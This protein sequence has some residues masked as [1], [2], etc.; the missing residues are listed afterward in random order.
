MAGS[1]TRSSTQPLVLGHEFAGV[2]EQGTLRGR[3]VAVDPAIPCGSC[4]PCVTGAVNLCLRTRF[5]GHGHDR[6]CAARVPRLA[7][8]RALSAAG[9]GRRP[10]WA[11]SS[12]RWRWRSTAWI[13]VE[14]AK[15]A[16]VGVIGCGPIGLLVVALARLAGA[17]TI[18]ATDPSPR[19]L[20]AA[21]HLGASRTSSRRTSDD[22]DG[23]RHA[24]RDERPGCGRRVRGRRRGGRGRMRGR[25]AHDRVA[26]SSCSG[27][28]RTI[29]PSSRRRLRV[30]RA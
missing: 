28:R 20:E 18:V 2:V 4:E 13:L 12:S 23:E 11:R 15:G 16:T 1:A 8:N 29:G 27:S 7:R 17:A 14:S 26:E 19:R 5:A 10:A 9:L 30:G 6:R 22:H 24:G 3:R 25:P 21:A